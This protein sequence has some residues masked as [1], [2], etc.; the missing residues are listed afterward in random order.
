MDKNTNKDMNKI[1]T[2]LM[3]A[4]G[5]FCWIPSPVKK[6]DDSSKKWMLTLMQIVGL[7]AGVIQLGVFALLGLLY[8]KNIIGGITVL[9]AAILTIVPFWMSGFIHLDGF[10]D[11]SDAMMSRKPIEDRQKILKDSRVGAFAVIMVVILFMLYFASVTEIIRC[12]RA[13]ECF[14]IIAFIPMIV[15]CLSSFDVL[16][17][18]ALATSQYAEGNKEKDDTNYGLI[19]L[20]IG[21]ASLVIYGIVCKI[22]FGS[23]GLFL[24]GVIAAIL[25]Q[26]ISRLIAVKSLGGMNGDIAGFAIVWGELIGVMAVACFA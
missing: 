15:R 10:M 14:A 26:V 3:M 8:A 4:W 13:L 1:V 21:M 22:A 25:G 7:V 20:A 17:L 5:N 11:C 19:C 16:R 9:P 2:G 24:I 18:P 6:W 23:I 12:L